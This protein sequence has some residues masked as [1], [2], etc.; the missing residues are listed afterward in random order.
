M[1]ISIK[2]NEKD[3]VRDLC[4]CV[5]AVYEEKDQLKNHFSNSSANSIENGRVFLGCRDE[6]TFLFEWKI[7]DRLM[8]LGKLIDREKERRML[9]E[10]QVKRNSVNIFI[11]IF[12]FDRCL[13][14]K[15]W[16]LCKWEMSYSDNIIEIFNKH[17]HRIRPIFRLSPN[18]LNLERNMLCLI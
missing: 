2:Y 18:F 1:W 9:A 8:I 11:F 13:S 5:C 7:F 4:R 15:L 10:I 6:D 16:L 3:K 17:L 14:L 12:A